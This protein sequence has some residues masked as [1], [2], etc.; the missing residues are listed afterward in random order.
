MCPCLLCACV[1][2]RVCLLCVSVCV[3]V[4]VC[5]QWRLHYTLVFRHIQQRCRVDGCHNSCP[6]AGASR[7]SD[8][9][10]NSNSSSSYE[11]ELLQLQLDTTCYSCHVLMSV[12]VCVCVYACVC[13]SACVLNIAIYHANAF[14]N[15]N[16]PPGIIKT[17][18][19]YNMSQ[20]TQRAAERERE[21]KAESG[22]PPQQKTKGKWQIHHTLPTLMTAHVSLS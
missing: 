22:F 20:H 15:F 21:S 18:Q 2:A 12:S 1:C 6:D 8:T 11:S 7:E 19:T 17:L 3:C 13:V 16:M 14:F 9:D 5:M 10:S 4:C